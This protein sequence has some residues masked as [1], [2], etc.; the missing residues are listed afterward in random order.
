MP[1]FWIIVLVLGGSAVAY[2]YVK[3]G[4]GAPEARWPKGITSARASRA[5]QIALARESD[6]RKLRAFAS[7]LERFDRTQSVKLIS[8]A[9]QIELTQLGILNPFNP[10]QRNPASRGAGPVV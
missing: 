7:V 10:S 2:T 4:P 1:L 8:K 5:V 3:A 6:P 9:R